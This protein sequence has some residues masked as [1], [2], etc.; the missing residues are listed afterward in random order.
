ME[1]AV[2]SKVS[3]AYRGT[4]VIGFNIYVLG[5]SDGTCCLNSCCC[6][7]AAMKTWREVAP[8]YIRRCYLSVTVLDDLM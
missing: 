1:E 7:N 3:R 2:D 8:M 6:F 4:T 5:G